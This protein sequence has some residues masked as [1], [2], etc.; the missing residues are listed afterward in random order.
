MFLEIIRSCRPDG[1]AAPSE[2]AQSPHQKAAQHP[3]AERTEGTQ[4]GAQP[5][6]DD[7][8]TM[9]LSEPTSDWQVC[10][11]ARA[12]CMQ[13]SD[14]CAIPCR[15]EFRAR[16]VAG[17]RQTDE[18]SVEGAREWAHPV[19]R[20]EKGCLLLAHPKMFAD[21]Q[22]YFNQA[23]LWPG[24]FEAWSVTWCPSNPVGEQWV[25][26]GCHLPSVQHT[27]GPRAA[28]RRLSS[29]SWSIQTRAVLD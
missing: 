27:C 9:P 25:A 29:S 12:Q 3:E 4:Q 11:L 6:E 17:S 13:G 21:S 23:S 20:P 18:A 24:Y 2:P 28:V 7:E 19:A 14:V 5:E 10:H 22:T 26:T 15:R 1:D 16:L 8:L